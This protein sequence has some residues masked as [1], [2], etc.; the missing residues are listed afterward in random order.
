M[1]NVIKFIEESTLTEATETSEC[2]PKNNH[3]F[4]NYKLLL[5]TFFF[6]QEETFQGIHQPIVSVCSSP[7]DKVNNLRICEPRVYNNLLPQILV[8]TFYQVRYISTITRVYLSHFRYSLEQKSYSQT[9]KK[10]YKED[11]C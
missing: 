1:T 6:Y 2:R 3:F 7:C 9:K 11:Y 5:S 4:S 8:K 10:N